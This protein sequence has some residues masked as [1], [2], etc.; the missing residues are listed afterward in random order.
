[1]IVEGAAAA[2]MQQKKVQWVIVG[3][4][5]IAANGDV[6]NKIGTYSLAV[7]ARH[8]DVKFMV[9]APSS[10]VD[11]SIASGLDIPIESRSEEEIFYAAGHRIAASGASAWNP[12]FDVTPASLVDV[13]VT[14][15]GVVMNPTHSKMLQMMKLSA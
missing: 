5:R 10:T 7:N 2:L 1:M 15:K 9:V 3:S 4:D 8:H 12:V 11:M 6:A 14:E 13:I